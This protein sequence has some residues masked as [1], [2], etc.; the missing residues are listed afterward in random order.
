MFHV[1]HS[2][3]KTPFR[4]DFLYL[5]LNELFHVERARLYANVYIRGLLKNLAKKLFVFTH[6]SDFM[7]GIFYAFSLWDFLHLRV[8]FLCIYPYDIAFPVFGYCERHHFP[9]FTTRLSETSFLATE[10]LQEHLSTIRYIL[11]P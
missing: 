8:A 3:E 4:T 1:K 11:F 2:Y 5:N 10:Y 6:Q 9:L 7:R